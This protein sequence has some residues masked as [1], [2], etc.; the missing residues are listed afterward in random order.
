MESQEY[1]IDSLE[2]TLQILNSSSDSGVA[3]DGLEDGFCIESGN[4]SENLNFLNLL[5]VESPSN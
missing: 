1:K 4:A 2:H 3:N 5:L